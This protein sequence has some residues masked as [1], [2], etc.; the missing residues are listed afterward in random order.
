MIRHCS[1]R[2]RALTLA[3]AASACLAGAP[4]AWAQGS[5]VVRPP[6][7]NEPSAGQ[8]WLY[9]LVGV[10]LGAM[11]VGVTILPSRRTHQD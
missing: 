3:L 10:G 7:V 9:Y 8:T 5:T 11:A 2:S 6:K 4:A 1:K